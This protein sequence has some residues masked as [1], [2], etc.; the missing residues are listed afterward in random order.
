MLLG[1]P[2]EKRKRGKNI[3]QVC[4]VHSFAGGSGSGMILP[5]LRMVKQSMPGAT[6]WVF[7]AGETEQGNSTHDAENVVYITSDILQARYNALHF[8]EKEITLK[9]WKNLQTTG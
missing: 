4:I 7:S 8:K 1:I 5:V 3:R 6:V 9:E 2:C